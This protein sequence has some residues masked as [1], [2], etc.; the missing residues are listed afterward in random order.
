MNRHRTRIL[1]CALALV[2]SSCTTRLVGDLD[3]AEANRIVSALERS[4]IPAAKKSTTS[5]RDRTWA[6]H[7]P[8]PEAQRAREITESL[9]LPRAK[10]GGFAALLEEASIVPSASREKLREDVA[11]GEEI[12]AAISRLDGVVHASVIIAPA[13]VRPGILAHDPAPAGATAS[14]LVRHTGK[15]S[16]T[17]EQVKELVAGAVAGVEPEAVAVVFSP[18]RPAPSSEPRWERIGPF[19]VARGSR[20]PLILVMAVMAILN[21]AL[22]CWVVLGAIRARRPRPAGPA[23]EIPNEPVG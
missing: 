10:P 21:I 12:A 20:T 18:T 8:A 2:L 3:E 9:A 16:V 15:P 13:P 6:V 14:V 11:R 4:G 1:A 19:A 23:P 22:G 7:V 17:E 5:G